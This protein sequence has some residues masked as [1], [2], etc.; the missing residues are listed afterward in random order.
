MLIVDM[1]A[2]KLPG[3]TKQNNLPH[4]CRQPTD[5]GDNPYDTGDQS[6]VNPTNTFVGRQRLWSLWVLNFKHIS[7]HF[8]K[9]MSM[10]GIV[11]HKAP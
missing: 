5:A 6:L 2:G 3:Q 7:A 1:S 4:E 8:L 10:D 9:K 11:T